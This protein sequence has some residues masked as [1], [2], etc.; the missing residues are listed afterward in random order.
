MQIEKKL[1][2][3]TKIAPAP[4]FAIID[5]F[6]GFAILLVILGHCIQNSIV[7]FDDNALFRIIY[8]FHMPLFMLLSGVV[9][10][11]PL[12]INIKAKAR[13]LLFPFL[14]FG[15]ISYFSGWMPINVFALFTHPDY[16]LW[17]LYTLFLINVWL[18]CLYKTYRLNK[19]MGIFCG[20]ILYFVLAY[21]T[22]AF[23][24]YLKYVIIGMLL[25]ASPARCMVGTSPRYSSLYGVFNLFEYMLALLF[26]VLIPF[27]HRVNP[28]PFLLTYH[29][30]STYKFFT[31]IC[32]IG[33]SHICVTYLN[34]IQLVQLILRK[35]G[36]NSLELYALHFY[37]LRLFS[38]PIN[39]I[40]ECIAVTS[41]TYLIIQILNY[42]KIG[43]LILFGS[44][45]P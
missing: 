18:F 12:N 9:I 35:L 14:S 26:I 28:S 1:I 38:S 31:A 24:L 2:E 42:S 5:T 32:G 20:T 15:L 17:F 3:K 40:L 23:S 13:R 8:S 16:G 45:K 29:L 11:L 25:R 22:P 19:Y 21:I 33:L 7:N 44:A 6:K 27:W 41:I 10:K 30:T 36:I 39:P 4:H 43:R 37:I 34:K